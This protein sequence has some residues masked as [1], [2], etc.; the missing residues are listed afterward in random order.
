MLGPEEVEGGGDLDLLAGL[1]FDQAQMPVQR[2]DAPA[3]VDLDRIPVVFVGRGLDHVAVRGS[4]NRIGI[5][6]SNIQAAVPGLLA[7]ERVDS[8]TDA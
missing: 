5:G 4:D 2:G 3:V 7:G 8:K 6:R 1:H